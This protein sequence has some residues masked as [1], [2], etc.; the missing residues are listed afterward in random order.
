MIIDRSGFKGTPYSNNKTDESF[1]I[2][3]H[4]KTD[5]EFTRYVHALLDQLL[6]NLKRDLYELVDGEKPNA[7]AEPGPEKSPMFPGSVKMHREANTSEPNGALLIKNSF[8]RSDLANVSSDIDLDMKY[9]DATVI[10]KSNGMVTE[11]QARLIEQLNFGEPIQSKNGTAVTMMNV[12]FASYVTLLEVTSNRRSFLEDEELE[13]VNIHTFVKLAVP[14]SDIEF[15]VKK[16]SDQGSPNDRS[17]SSGTFTDHPEANTTGT[18]LSGQ[19]RTRRGITSTLA[20]L[21]DGVIQKFLDSSVKKT[22][23]IFEKKVIGINVKGEITVSVESIR[24]LHKYKDYKIDLDLTL[25]FGAS[26]RVKLLDDSIPSSQIRSG[27]SSKKTLSGE[28]ITFVSV[29]AFF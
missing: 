11:G 23:T 22:L 6:P 29:L 15:R 26:I 13:D 20:N 28:G 1:E 2:Y 14:K 25:R 16:Q 17:N 24:T 19:R 9:S 8:N 4:R 5:V 7:D 27:R 12:T 18:L 3:G 21:L 10:N